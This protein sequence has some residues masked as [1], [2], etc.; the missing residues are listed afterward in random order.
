VTGGSTTHANTPSVVSQGYSGSSTFDNTGQTPYI[1]KTHNN[2][3]T[4][5]ST[6]S[7][8]ND[9]PY[10]TY[11]LIYMDLAAWEASV[12][13]L[14]INA[15]VLS[16]TALTW[17]E[18]TRDADADGKIVQIA[19]AGST[20]G[21]S[22]RNHTAVCSLG[23]GG[24]GVAAYWDVSSGDPPVPVSTDA[25]IYETHTHGAGSSATDAATTIPY[26]VVT[27]L[28]KATVQTT[29]ALTGMIA[30]VDGDP[31]SKWD[32]LSGSWTNAYI[33]GGDQ[34]A[35]FTGASTHAHANVAF[36]SG[37]YY[38]AGGG[39]VY[40]YT[41]GDVAIVVG[42]HTHYLTLSLATTNHEPLNVKLY[43]V[44]LN[45]TL[46]SGGSWGGTWGG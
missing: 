3:S 44:K 39:K 7:A 29:K 5:P 46:T 34:D 15:V 37:S 23:S 11:D 24:D 16:D 43:P 28:Y 33:M 4:T 40:T 35:A 1:E 25:R 36:N 9:P 19:T 27:R 22:T 32:A 17:S 14:P 41:G 38:G 21:T 20:G 18:V 31:G 26:H 10:Y 45:T 12:K 8:N 2:H 6:T 13:C 42:G 30:F